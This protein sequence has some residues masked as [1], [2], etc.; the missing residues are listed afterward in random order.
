LVTTSTSVRMAS[1]SADQPVQ[2]PRITIAA[3]ESLRPPNR[4]PAL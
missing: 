1:D 3:P 4:W 2:F